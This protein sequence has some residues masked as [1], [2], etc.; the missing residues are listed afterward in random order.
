MRVLYGNFKI[1][2]KTSNLRENFKR[3]KISGSGDLYSPPT[4]N[5]PKFWYV[6]DVHKMSKVRDDGG[7]KRM[8]CYFHFATQTIHTDIC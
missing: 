4:P 5:P 1:F 3:A 8:Q 7:E 6:A 2:T